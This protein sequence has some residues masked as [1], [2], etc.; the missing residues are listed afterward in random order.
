MTRE[1]IS[2]FL[3]AY[4]DGVI[5]EAGARRL[6]ETLRAGGEP[7]EWVM[8]ELAFSGWIA[9]ALATLDEPTFVRSFLERLYA[10]RGG[11]D[12]Q[13]AFE[14]RFAATRRQLDGPRPS[15]WMKKFVLWPVM[16]RQR[17]AA[18]KSLRRGRLLPL[19]GLA[20]GLAVLFVAGRLAVRL[21]MDI[22]PVTVG[23][24]LE[25]SPGVVVSRGSSR[26]PVEAGAALASRDTV[27]VPVNGHLVVREGT[28]DVWRFRA[29]AIAT[30]VPRE[31]PMKRFVRPAG[32]GLF[33]QTGEMLADQRRLDGR[34]HDYVMTP[35]AVAEITRPT[36]FSVSVTAASTRL[37][38]DSGE[39]SFTR[40]ADGRVLKLR[41]GFYA[42]ATEGAEFEAIER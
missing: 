26:G 14:Q 36:R 32:N 25:A 42:V 22:R 37:E 9:Q 17:A 41:G 23:T 11:A 16:A 35:H 29:G 6:A 2:D 8:S 5:D 4:R 33:L 18:I 30:F 15:V 7:A 3:E 28:A 21:G 12:F 10:E 34:A 20:A 13:R 27:S 1:E 40:H 39:V 31:L 38:V 24:V 19:A